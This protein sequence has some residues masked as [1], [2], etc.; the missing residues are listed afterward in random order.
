MKSFFIKYDKTSMYIS[1]NFVFIGARWWVGGGEGFTSPRTAI[2][3]RDNLFDC[4]YRGFV[5]SDK[6][7][8]QEVADLF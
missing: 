6:T 3:L 8:D 2:H 4:F 1:S 7:A 5:V